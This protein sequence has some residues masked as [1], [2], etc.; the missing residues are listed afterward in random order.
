MSYP[1]MTGSYFYVQDRLERG[2]AYHRRGVSL[3]DSLD[4]YC[5]RV[6]KDPNDKLLLIEKVYRHF[7]DACGKGLYQRQMAKL[8]RSGPAEP[9][10]RERLDKLAIQMH[11]WHGIE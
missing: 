11:H 9:G 2:P 5:D 8:A 7:G 3:L 6:V 4:E 1:I 10:L